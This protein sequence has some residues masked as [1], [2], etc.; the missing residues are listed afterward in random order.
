VGST[1]SKA[2]DDDI[3]L[4]WDDDE[5]DVDSGWEAEDGSPGVDEPR[6]A[7]SRAAAESGS[8]GPAS[9]VRP[10]PPRDEGARKG[11]QRAKAAEKNR[12][13]KER[14][15]AA[16]AKQKKARSRDEAPVTE[17]RTKTPDRDSPAPARAS[18]AAAKRSETRTE[19]ARG[20][21]ARVTPRR[22]VPLSVISVLVIL[23]IAGAVGLLMAQ[24]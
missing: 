7:A 23:G 24:R 6:A 21:A 4:G 17:V 12:R 5:E 20:D 11:R 14:A 1:G 13:Q 8:V 10:R 9:E 16:A 3:D 19:P 22:K 15:A 2:D 18:P